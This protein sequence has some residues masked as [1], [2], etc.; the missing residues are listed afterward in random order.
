MNPEL[1]KLIDFALADGVVTDKEREIVRR[2]AEKLGEDPDEAEMILDAKLAMQ[3]KDAVSSTPPSPPPIAAPPSTPPPAV[4][5]P[6]QKQ[7]SSKVGDIMTC[8]ACGA[9]VNAMELNCSECGHEFRNIESSDNSVELK[10]HLSR[11]EKEVRER[12][13]KPTGFFNKL[14]NTIDNMDAAS[15]SNKQRIIRGDIN[16]EQAIY[17]NNYQIKAS[18]GAIKEV[19]TLATG[20]VPPL[21]EKLAIIKRD[22]QSIISHATS[23]A[24]VRAEITG[25]EDIISAWKTCV[26]KAVSIIEISD[27]DNEEKDKLLN[28]SRK[29]N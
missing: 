8:P 27:I 12:H 26:S 11:I 23:G 5:P 17:I 9:T 1:E 7:K 21:E 28:L 19:L 14:M 3:N 20:I 29:I 24:S 2:K 16:S 6:T 25:L 18:K 13:E 15:R 10:N 4:P 22:N